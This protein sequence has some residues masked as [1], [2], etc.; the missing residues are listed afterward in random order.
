MASSVLTVKVQI[1]GVRET[2]AAF[3]RLPK[4]ASNELRDASGKLAK[5]L[6]AKAVVDA[7]AHGGPQGA[8]LAE[9]VKVVRDR[10]PA[11]Q[12]GGTRKVGRNR[13]PAYSLLFGSVFGMSTKSGWY[14]AAR[15]AGGRSRQYRAHRG[16]NAYWFFPLV[17]REA[18]T[19]S[20]E[21]NAAADAIVRKFSEGGEV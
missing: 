10:V 6:A 17:E 12:V 7:H 3:Q 2:L 18:S 9:T 19:I 16:Q 11:I 14:A 5:A 15:F 1:E 21:W 20:R 4:D 8:L 13:T